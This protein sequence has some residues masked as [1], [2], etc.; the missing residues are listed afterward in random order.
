MKFFGDGRIGYVRRKLITAFTQEK[1]RNIGKTKG[2]QKAVDEALAVLAGS[3]SQQRRERE[4]N[5]RAAIKMRQH[6]TNNIVRRSARIA[7]RQG[8]CK[9]ENEAQQSKSK[10]KSAKEEQLTVRR[11]SRLAKS[12]EVIQRRNNELQNSCTFAKVECDSKVEKE[13]ERSKWKGK[14]AKEEELTVR[15]SSR[16]AT[17]KM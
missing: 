11:S 15:R 5:T 8:G 13:A 6:D 17:K 1:C 16:L 14:S 2:L 9:V 4:Q 12:H 10:D 3:Q 7:A